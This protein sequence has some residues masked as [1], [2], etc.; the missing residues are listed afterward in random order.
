MI[1]NKITFINKDNTEFYSVLKKNIDKYFI[2]NKISKFANTEMVIKTIFMLS[3]YLVPYFLI[4]SSKFSENIMLLFVVLMGIGLA[5]IGMCVMHDANHNSYSPLPLINRV[6][7]YTLNLIGASEYI[8]RIKHN[9]IHHTYTNIYNSDEDIDTYNT[10]RISVLEK[11]KPLHKYQNIYAFIV[12]GLVT[13]E[14]CLTRDFLS[15]KRYIKKGYI[16]KYSKKTKKELTILIISKV[17]YFL[18]TIVIPLLVLDIKWW[19][20]FIGFFILH[21]TAGIILA[22]V[23]QLAH[24]VEKTLFPEP[25]KQSKIYTE[26]AIH[27]LL[28]TANFSRKN[29]ILSWFIGGLNYQIE[30]H[31]FPN[32]CHV[33]YRK[34]S[35]IVKKTSEQF[36]LPYNEYNNFSD[37]LNSH[38]KVLKKLGREN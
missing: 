30:H 16:K 11:L 31:L 36:G 29:K 21:F 9:I 25:D 15:F 18:F 6:L 8:W 32:I 19:K 27:Q 10:M 24:V 22:T 1:D 34:I 14:W 28:T 4:T 38:F 20:V 5:G 7:G 17:L 2:D 33:H 12:Y 23:F 35:E 26:W 3:L 37:A 13:L